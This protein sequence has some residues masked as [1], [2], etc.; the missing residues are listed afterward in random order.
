MEDYYV[1]PYWGT[2]DCPDHRRREEERLD[3]ELDRQRPVRLSREKCPEDV[4]RYKG[5]PVCKAEL[6]FRFVDEDKV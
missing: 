4:R 2:M 6:G 3:R 1:C 5:A